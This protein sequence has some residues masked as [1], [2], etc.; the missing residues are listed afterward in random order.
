MVYR[1]DVPLDDI[2]VNM[3]EAYNGNVNVFQRFYNYLLYSR[4]EDEDQYKVQY[5]PI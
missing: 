3:E 5:K 1:I 2:L 4:L